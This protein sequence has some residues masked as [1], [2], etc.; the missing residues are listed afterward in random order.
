MRRPLQI[1]R[2]RHIL[3]QVMRRILGTVRLVEVAERRSHPL[4]LFRSLQIPLHFGAHVAAHRIRNREALIVPARIDRRQHRKQSLIRVQR[5]R[6]V[7]LPH[8]NRGQP[9]QQRRHQQ[10]PKPQAQETTQENLPKDGCSKCAENILKFKEFRPE[11]QTPLGDSY[12]DGK[13]ATPPP[14]LRCHASPHRVQDSSSLTP[15]LA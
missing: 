5:N 11:G 13:T 6:R 12:T 7:I 14:G 4:R 9:P 8:T 2:H 10:S 3:R 15:S 1:Q